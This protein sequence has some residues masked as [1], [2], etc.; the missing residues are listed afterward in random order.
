MGLALQSIDKHSESILFFDKVM[1]K[2]DQDPLTI[3]KTK[4]FLLQSLFALDKRERFLSELNDLIGSGKKNALIGSFCSRAKIRYGLHTK[5]PFCNEP[6]NYV[7]KT[8]LSRNYDFENLF[9]KPALS[10]LENR[11]VS[12]R[13][14]SL[15]NN[16]EQTSGN[17]L[18]GGSYF[19]DQASNAIRLEIDKYRRKFESRNEGLILNWPDEYNISGWLVR[20]K[21]GGSVSPHIHE[22]GW[23][24]GSIYINVPKSTGPNDGNLFVSLDDKEYE[25][26]GNLTNGKIIEV[27]TG[28]LCLFPASLHHCTIPFNSPE[29]R[30]VLAF[31][32]IP[33]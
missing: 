5:N 27:Q 24:S 26:R 32:I 6:L 16:A 10:I 33:N 15:L 14:Q 4:S 17:I 18:T 7:V 19:S 12:I 3:D 31:D 13:Y 11:K 21:N 8:T 1:A 23:L 25:Q 30:I 29:E 22:T 20:Y 28:T 2:K 9:R